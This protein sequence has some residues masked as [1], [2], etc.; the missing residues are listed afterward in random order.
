MSS[1]FKSHL[2]QA[3]DKLSCYR[4][5]Y[6]ILISETMYKYAVT[7]MLL[8]LQEVQKNLPESCLNQ[9]DPTSVFFYLV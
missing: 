9:L 5:T 8:K 4:F 2:V 3:W 6:F 7:L 1:I